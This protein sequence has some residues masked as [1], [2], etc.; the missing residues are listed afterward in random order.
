MLAPNV[1]DSLELQIDELE[2]SSN[3][4]WKL[5][6]VTGYGP[7]STPAPLALQRYWGADSKTIIIIW[8]EFK[9]NILEFVYSDTI[10]ST[11]GVFVFRNMFWIEQLSSERTRDF[12]F[13]TYATA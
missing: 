1:R 3:A 12:T 13:S 8:D 11:V 2:G 7:G 5:R 9:G 10:F 6:V 4:H